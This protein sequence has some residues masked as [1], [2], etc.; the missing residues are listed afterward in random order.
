MKH[1]KAALYLYAIRDNKTYQLHQNYHPFL[2]H[3][4]QLRPVLK[5][6]KCTKL[7]KKY[8]MSLYRTRVAR[9]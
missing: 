1:Y 4:L 3:Q 8:V 6:Q 9:E 2:S 5:E 7:H